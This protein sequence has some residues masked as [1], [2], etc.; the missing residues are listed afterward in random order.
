[1]H[2]TNSGLHTV[3][4]WMPDSQIQGH[5]L[6]MYYEHSFGTQIKLQLEKINQREKSPQS[7]LYFSQNIEK[8]ND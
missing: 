7:C 2:E 3:Q 1:M 4:Q 5:W 6:G 8:Y